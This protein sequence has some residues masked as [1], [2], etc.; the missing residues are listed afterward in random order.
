LGDFKN[1]VY[2]GIGNMTAESKKFH[3]NGQLQNGKAHGK[4]KLKVFFNLVKL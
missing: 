4:G 1:G 2:D 3:Y